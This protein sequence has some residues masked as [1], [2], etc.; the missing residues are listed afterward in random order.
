MNLV[1][2]LFKVSTPE[3]VIKLL[4]NNLYFKKIIQNDKEVIDIID[5][6]YRILS[7]EIIVTDNLP[8]FNR[9][10]MDGYAIK[11]GDSFGVS[12]SLPSYLKVIGEIQM[13]YK[14]EF[15]IGFGEAAK[16]STGGMLPEGTNAVMMLEYTEE[17]D[18]TSIEVR[19]S[20]SPWE[21]VV[22]ED[23]DLKAGEIILKKGH[24]LRPQDIGALA[25]IGKVNIEAYKKPKIAIISTGN[26]I[27]PIQNKPRIGQV[28][29][30]NSY[31]LGTCVE[32]AQGIPICKGII[33]DENHLL[34]KK[35][36]EAI[37]RDKAKMVLISGGSSVGSRDIT[38]DVLNKLGNPGVLIHGVSVKPGKPTIVAVTN[39]IPIFGLPGHPVSAMIIF[40]LFIRPLINWLQGGEYDCDLK[41]K[42]EAEI[43]SNVASDPGREE[44]IRVFLYRKEGKFYAKPILGKS[45][46]IS[47][48]IHASGLI[49]I[50][51]NIE[52]VEKGSKVMVRL[53]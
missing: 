39:D 38:L 53:F 19:K 9:S 27:I 47:N 33:R 43:D 32:E 7:K 26:E 42:I 10:T 31:T 16:I 21:N 18:D 12:D 49:K 40:D 44:Y 50:S 22:R 28:R 34:E 8:G 51:L 23:E 24:K 41:A 25:G 30:V 48:M 17:I 13:G 29:D 11:A 35:I 3:E 1:R 46:L 45:G 2:P 36:R 20:I 15:K 52:G 37:N 4:K 14:P 6:L 5:A